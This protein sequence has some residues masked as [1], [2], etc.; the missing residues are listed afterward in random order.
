MTWS[1]RHAELVSASPGQL[2][3]E[4]PEDVIINSD[5]DRLCMACELISFALMQKKQK[6]KTAG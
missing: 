3:H 5:D 6:I 2:A 4:N 1:K